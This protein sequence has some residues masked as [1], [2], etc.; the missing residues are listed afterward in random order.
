MSFFNYYFLK[1]KITINY[2]SIPIVIHKQKTYFFAYIYKIWDSFFIKTL[3]FPSLSISPSVGSTLSQQCGF[4][5]IKYSINFF[6]ENVYEFNFHLLKWKTILCGNSYSGHVQ[7]NPDRLLPMMFLKHYREH[8]KANDRDKRVIL[9]FNKEITSSFFSSV[10]KVA[11]YLYIHS[12]IA[13]FC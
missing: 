11:V 6:I 12:Y 8:R 2:R 1:Y 7:A 9:T 5:R 4:S 13:Y 10:E 3:I